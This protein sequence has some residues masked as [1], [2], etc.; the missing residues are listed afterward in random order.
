MAD[1]PNKCSNFSSSDPSPCCC[2][3]VAFSLLWHRSWQDN[4]VKKEEP[5]K[6]EDRVRHGMRQEFEAAGYSSSDQETETDE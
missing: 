3:T 6:F 2:G 5:V 4:T 1:N